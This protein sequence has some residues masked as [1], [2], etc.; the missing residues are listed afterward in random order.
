MPDVTPREIAVHLA[1]RTRR[2]DYQ[3][4]E[5]LLEAMRRA[6]LPAPFLC[7]QAVCG[8]CMVRC[9][10]G[11]VILRENHVLSEDDLAHGYRLACQGLPAGEVCEIEIQG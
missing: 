7:E 10:R 8:T 9:L 6:G 3:P 11:D 4:G 2:I 1:G 5:T